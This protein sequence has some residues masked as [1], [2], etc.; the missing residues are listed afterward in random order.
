MKSIPGWGM[1]SITKQ[2]SFL[3][4]ARDWDLSQVYI[5]PGVKYTYSCVHIVHGVHLMSSSLKTTDA[6][7]I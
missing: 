3:A 2:F 1:Q 7:V 4:M 6:A 5:V